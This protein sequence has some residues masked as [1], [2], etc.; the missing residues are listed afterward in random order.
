MLLS[1]TKKRRKMVQKKFQEGKLLQETIDGDK[2]HYENSI[3][4]A[5]D[6]I[7]DANVILWKA[8][9]AKK[10]DRNVIQNVQPKTEIGIDRKTGSFE[11]EES[12]IITVI[13]L[14]WYIGFFSFFM[15]Y[16]ID[17]WNWLLHYFFLFLL[18]SA[19]LLHSKRF[20]EKSI[21][22]H[23]VICNCNVCFV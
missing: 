4:G 22:M 19:L 6:I 18:S 12:W 1:E 10:L 15:F 13:N 21:V 7:A 16:T 11:K 20:T 17:I 14:Y 8:L 9:L 23:Q 3:K 5:D 2:R